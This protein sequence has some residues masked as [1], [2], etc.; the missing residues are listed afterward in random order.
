MKYASVLLAIS[1]LLSAV[2][3]QWLETTIQLDSA[4]APYA[5]CYNSQNNKVYCANSGRGTVTVVDGATNA[6]IATVTT[7]GYPCALCY[8]PQDNKVYCANGDSSGNVTVID[9]VTDSVITA[10]AAGVYP[11]DICYNPQAGKVYF[12][13]GRSPMTAAP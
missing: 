2:K 7:G 8:N 12:A 9:G 5:L 13:S 1:C 6:A 11:G 4:S 3:A 10:V